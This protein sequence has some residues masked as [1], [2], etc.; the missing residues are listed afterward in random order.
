MSPV[1][2]VLISSFDGF[3]DCWVPSAHGFT[4]YWPD[5]PYPILL[6]TNTR[7]FPHPRLRVLKVS[8][9]ADWSARMIDALDRIETPYVIYFQEDYWI[10][11]P[12]DTARI[13]SYLDLM[14]REG[15]DYIR[16][17][18]NPVPDREYA[19]DPRLGVLS[20]EASYRTSVQ[21]TLWRREVFRELVVPGESVWQ[22]EINGTERSRKYGPTFLGAKRVGRDDYYH[23]IRYLCTAVNAG[24]WF[25]PAWDYVRREGLDVD[26]SGRP[27]EN[28]WEHYRRVTPWGRALGVA[29]HRGRMLLTHPS[30]AF[31]KLRSRLRG[32]QKA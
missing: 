1:A 20:D 31:R 24:K 27:T 19:P 21:I 16:L 10:T 15:L 23:G 13:T 12:V 11:E 2:T 32:D 17:V 3:A 8:G 14:E 9:G 25:R 5:C 4:K 22:F 26:L 6:M 18:S 7:D 29:G 30:L 28:L